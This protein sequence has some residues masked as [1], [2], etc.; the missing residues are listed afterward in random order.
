MDNNYLAAILFFAPAGIANAAP[1]IANRI[2]LWNRWKTPVDFGRSWH[3]KRLTGANKTW[4]GIVSGIIL[5][6]LS[7][8]L[9]GKLVPETIVN[10][11]VFLT[12]ALLGVGALVGDAV[13]SCVKRQ[14]GITPGTKW[15]PWDQI[16]YIVGGL[17]FVLPVADLPLWA[18]VT[19]IIAYFPLHL[20]FAY[21]GYLLG[22]KSTPI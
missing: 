13:E 6:G 4:R 14:L 22:L 2:P 5:G 10:D 20:L 8:L 1:V 21:I 17:I 9:I 3:G 18:I 19:I 12:G 16:D 11:Q 7:A 15:F